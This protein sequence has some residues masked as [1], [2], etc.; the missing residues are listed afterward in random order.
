MFPYETFYILFHIWY[1]FKYYNFFCKFA[2]KNCK[3]SQ[4]LAFAKFCVCYFSL[5]KTLVEWN[6]KFFITMLFM[7]PIN[8]FAKK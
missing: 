7:Y 1:S 8:K 6:E 2:K 4:I 5:I 3:K